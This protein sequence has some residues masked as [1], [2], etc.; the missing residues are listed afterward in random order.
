ME[1]LWPES[2]EAEARLSA[3]HIIT[4]QAR[5]L[6]KITDGFAEARVSEVDAA[7]AASLGM[8]GSGR[9]IFKLEIV[10]RYISNYKYLVFY[11][12]HD[13]TLYPVSFRMERELA[14]EL[15]A[16]VVG[17]GFQVEIN[18]EDILRQFLSAT[19]RSDRIRTVV[20]SIVSLSR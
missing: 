7:S 14:A 8:L 11:F 3:K 10:G 2:F 1:S 12:W 19:L 13:I 9:F 6:S 5:I 16:P 15:K 18:N 17:S 4:E 20:G